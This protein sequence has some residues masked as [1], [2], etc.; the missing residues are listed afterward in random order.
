MQ[1]WCSASAVAWTWQW[2][3]Y[4]GVW[5]LVAALAVTYA[6]L[7]RG[8]APPRRDRALG[9][10]GVALIWLS[11]DWPLGPLAAGYLASVHAVQFLLVAMIAPPLLLLGART[12]IEA[13]YR[14]AP[15]SS[16]VRQLLA[17]VTGPLLAAILFN[18]VTVTTHVPM[19]V[20]RLMVTQA[21]AFAIDAAWLAG[22]LVFWYPL[23]VRAPARPLFAPG[24][25]MLYL[26]LGTLFH[27]GIAIAMLIRDF[28]MYRVYELA[29]PMTGLSAIDDIKIAGGIMEL[30]GAVIVFGVLTGM[31]F[32]W[33][34]AAGERA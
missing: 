13:W 32:R 31:F 8:L 19:V 9:W 22:G 24:M 29:P 12:G 4:P 10:L 30:A 20:D 26:F 25:Q 27:T 18:L 33:A 15:D 6:R 3:A 14:G 23:V 2:V 16:G 21:G 11:L 17:I 34:R 5:L 1:W 7:V 28:P